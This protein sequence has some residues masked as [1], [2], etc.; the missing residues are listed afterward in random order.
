[1]KYL[2][3]IASGLILNLVVRA[4]DTLLYKGQLSGYAYYNPS[5]QLP[6]WAGAR[7]IPQI[8]AK[9]NLSN[10]KLFDF[11]MSANIFGNLGSAPFTEFET[12][13]TIKP[14]RAW[15]RYSGNQF[16]VRLGLQ[17]INFGS[18][19]M[20]RPL[21][22]FDQLD[23]RDPLQL[24]DGV[25][26][27]LGRYYFLNNVN[28]WIWGLWGNKDPKMWETGKTNQRFP[29]TGLRAQ[30]PVLNGELALTYH[31]RVADTREFTELA[32]P[33]REVPENRI[34]LDGK[35]DLGPGIWFEVVWINKAKKSGNLTNQHMIN[36][37]TDYT[38]GIGNGLNVIFEQIAASTGE[39][40]LS[41]ESAV[42]F[43]GI[44]ATYPLSMFNNL[45]GIMYF[46]W[47]NKSS[48][49]FISWKTQLNKFDLNIMA[50]WNPEKYI[51][52][53]QTSSRMMMGG[54][55]IQVVI[56]HNH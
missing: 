55:G 11:E 27:L 52:P 10:S 16:E 49:N 26:G 51:I 35:W 47:R 18:A 31:F 4:N 22:W 41:F 1:M 29:E 28:I 23:P 38:F 6:V 53:I 40:A 39:E 43:S 19:M 48:Y 21:M 7:Y 33:H 12:D 24:T 36:I 56:V 20:L 9:K 8:N 30:S 14:Y 25:W 44:A 5:N 37:G 3:L 15:L 42:W 54:K 32:E 13:G 46:D 50:F 2:L 17:K 34:G 45:Q